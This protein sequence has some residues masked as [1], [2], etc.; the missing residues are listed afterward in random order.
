MLNKSSRIS[1]FIVAMCAFVSGCSQ[2]QHINVGELPDDYRTN[3]P[4]RVVKQ[5]RRFD[6]ALS[7]DMKKLTEQH[8]QVL[9]YAFALYKEEGVG[10]IIVQRPSDTSNAKAGVRI[11]KAAIGYL[12]NQGLPNSAILQRQYN[13]RPGASAV[14][15]VTFESYEAKVGPCGRWPRDILDTSD[16]KHYANFGCSVQN[17]LAAQVANPRDLI[18]PRVS[19]SI[20]AER[21]QYVLQQYRSREVGSGASEID[22]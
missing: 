21:R 6:L 14:V 15:R 17:N 10:G 13:V 4:I 5:E 11:S 16:N 9:G 1:L 12:R 3:H 8:N 19:T 22:Y 18:Q 2:A 7:P 20:D